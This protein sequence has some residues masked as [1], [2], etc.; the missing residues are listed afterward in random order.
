MKL[1]F[2][3]A[4]DSFSFES[5]LYVYYQA[6]VGFQKRSTLKWTHIQ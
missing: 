2:T 6:N 1:Y 4:L 5:A 3:Y